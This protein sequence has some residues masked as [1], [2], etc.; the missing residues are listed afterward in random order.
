M[1]AD[2]ISK[3]HTRRWKTVLLVLG[4]ATFGGVAFVLWNRRELA[5]IHAKRNAPE[6]EAASAEQSDE[7]MF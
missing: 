1:T 3:P 2:P 5:Q 7:E 6:S 4:S